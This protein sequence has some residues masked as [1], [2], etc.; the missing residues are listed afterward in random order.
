MNEN[1]HLQ[2][3][4]KDLWCV[5]GKEGKGPFKFDIRMTAVRLKSGGLLLHSPVPINDSLSAEIQA[6]GRVEHVVA[7]NCFHH[8]YAS[9][10]KRM[11]PDATLWAAPGLNLKRGEIEFDAVI[12]DKTPDWGDDLEYKFI[13]GMPIINE[14]VFFHRPSRTF[15]CTDFLFNIR[16]GSN[17]LIRSIWR[18]FGVWKKFGQSRSWRF[19]IKNR[20]DVTRSV[21]SILEWKFERVIMAHGDIVECDRYRLY[22]ILKKTNKDIVI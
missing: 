20:D 15:I 16:S 11:F 19:M 22:E 9:Q 13:V 17:V 10:T 12:G 21:N 5:G 14:I 4:D 3:I 8:L 6:L 18:L 1:E 7:P 2:I